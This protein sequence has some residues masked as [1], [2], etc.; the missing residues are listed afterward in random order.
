MRSV[1]KCRSTLNSEPPGSTCRAVIAGL[2]PYSMMIRTP[3]PLFVDVDDGALDARGDRLADAVGQRFGQPGDPVQGPATEGERD[4]QVHDLASRLADLDP[5][6]ARRGAVG[7]R[8]RPLAR[9]GPCVMRFGRWP[10]RSRRPRASRIGPA[11]AAVRRPSATSCRTRSMASSLM[12]AA[13]SSRAASRRVASATSISPRSRA[14]RMARLGSG[15]E[16]VTPT[17]GRRVSAS[18]PAVDG[19]APRVATVRAGPAARARLAAAGREAAAPATAQG[20]AATRRPGPTGGRAGGRRRW[21][22]A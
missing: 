4:A 2:L 16:S 19:R 9:R 21:T 8:L 14:S 11:S 17:P 7:G 13:P 20:P 6:R 22:G 3:P 1:A 18:V 5:D 15:V 10:D 12:I